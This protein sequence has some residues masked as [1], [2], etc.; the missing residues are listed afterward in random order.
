[1]FPYKLLYLTCAK[2]YVSGEFPLQAIASYPCNNVCFPHKLLLW[3]HSLWTLQC[4]IWLQATHKLDKW[5]YAVKKIY[6]SDTEPLEWIR[7]RCFTWGLLWYIYPCI[8]DKWHCQGPMIYFNLLDI[9]LVMC[10]GRIPMFDLYVGEIELTQLK[11]W[12]DLY[13]IIFTSQRQPGVRKSQFEHNWHNGIWL[14]GVHWSVSLWQ[15]LY[16]PFTSHA[17]SY[18]PWQRTRNKETVTFCNVSLKTCNNEGPL[19]SFKTAAAQ[20]QL[21]SKHTLPLQWLIYSAT[22][23]IRMNNPW[24]I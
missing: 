18:F 16:I 10:S 14:C 24:H 22:N 12:L 17:S 6:V 15:L 19:P 20:I 1:M 9:P 11:L 23:R 3:Q 8:L 13:R 2:I 4:L 21:L 5:N 7:V